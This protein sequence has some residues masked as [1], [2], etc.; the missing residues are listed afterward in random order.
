MNAALR[1]DPRRTVALTIDMQRMYLDPSVGGKLLPI[2]EANAIVEASA[3][4]LDGCRSLGVP[5]VHVYVNRRQVEID[6]RGDSGFT[7]SSRAVSP[8]LR[9]PSAAASIGAAGIGAGSKIPDRLEGSPQAEVP[10]VMVRDSDIHIRTKKTTDSYLGTDLGLL[11]ERTLRP[12]NVVI[13]GIN[14][15]TC[16]YAG[17]FATS[18]RDYQPVIASD[19]VGSHRGRDNTWMALELMSRGLAWVMPSTQILEK[20]AAG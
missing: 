3:R 16:V 5:V 14:T 7:R 9:P 6:A 11:F 17:A 19:C 4:F 2:D 1:M 18:V 12:E 10:A 15:D 13:M 20:L 8:D